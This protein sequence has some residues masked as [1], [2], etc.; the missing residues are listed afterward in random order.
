MAHALAVS[1]RRTEAEEILIGL[2][3]DSRHSYVSPWLFAVIYSGLG[4]KD[5]AFDW[6]EKSYQRRGHNMVYLRVWP[7]FDNLRCDPR[8]QALL[9]RMNFPK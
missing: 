9:R 8:F 7:Q 4:D 6:L 1:G 3:E 2:R 5:Q